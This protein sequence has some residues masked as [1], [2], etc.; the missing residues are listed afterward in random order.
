MIIIV[1]LFTVRS[2]Q[3]A[4]AACL[5]RNTP[6]AFSRTANFFTPGFEPMRGSLGNPHSSERQAHWAAH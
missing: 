4:D 5:K 3:L 2:V 1:P 6:A